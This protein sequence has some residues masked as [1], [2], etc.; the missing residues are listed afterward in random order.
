MFI[1]SLI[2]F[3]VVFA[4]P[5]NAAVNIDSWITDKGA[6]V[7]FVKN[8][9][10]P[11]I[12][13]EVSFKAGSA[14]DRLESAGTASLTNHMML[15]GSDN[16]KQ[17]EIIN[18]FTEIG[19]EIGSGF[20]QDKSSFSLRTLSEKKQEAFKLFQLVLHKPNFDKDIVE[21][22]KQRY[23]SSIRQS[24]TLPDSIGSKA[25]M[26]AMYG[27][28]SYALPSSG[29]VESVEKI[30]DTDLKSFYD[31]TY[32]AKSAV[33]VIV[34]DLSKKEA[35]LF[36]NQISHDLPSTK[37]LQSLKEVKLN[38]SHT[39]KIDHPSSQAHLHFGYPIMKR[40]DKDFFP[41]YVGNYILGGG[42]FVSRLTEEVREKKGYVYSVYSYFM[43]MQEKGPFQIGLQTK[44]EQIDQAFDLVKKV[45]KE[46][47]DFGPTEKELVAAKSNMVGGFPLRLDSN[48]K[49]MNYISMMAF[50]NYPLDYL[51]TFSEKVKAV[52]TEQIKDAFKRRVKLDEFTTVIVGA[53]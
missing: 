34:G 9:D 16:L 21:R 11:I 20:D 27:D 37:N 13:V 25:F 3:F 42:G 43:P 24:D 1:R 36:A 17:E 22:E 19:A 39:I 18:K 28:H 4:F 30:N 15:L 7:L 35:T 6:R 8:H 32:S 38:Q 41:L 31:S 2:L 40:G 5:V 52:T 10:L 14:Y 23:I 29:F 47:I 53:S 44:K 50:Y 12:D 48:K 51:E 46:F 49:I 33:I 45:V 26:K